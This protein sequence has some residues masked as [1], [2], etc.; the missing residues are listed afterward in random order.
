M[1]R[2]AL[3]AFLLLSAAAARAVEDDAEG[4]KDPQQLKRYPGTR[5]NSCDDKEYDEAEVPVR[6]DAEKNEVTE[7]LGGHVQIYDYNQPEHASEIQISRNIE[8]ALSKAGY[9]I[10]VGNK[11]G[12]TCCDVTA[13]SKNLYVAAQVSGGGINV[14]IIEVKPMEQKMDAPDASAM[15]E[16]LNKSGHVAVYGINFDT[17]KSNLKDDSESVLTE[18]AKLLTD[19]AD[20]K[21][22]VEGH[23]DNQ[24]KSKENLALSKKR[25][26][27]VK[28]WLV[29][30][31]VEA[32]RL[33]TEGF[34]DQKPVGDNKTDEGK[35]K[36]RRVELV[37]L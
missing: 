13:Q 12:A 11:T 29:K 16:E 5:L 37:K 6:L 7:K 22:R 10:L 30:K 2:L 34:G 24:G 14:R 35:A 31:G 18:V 33:T 3:I 9:K 15:L 27:A 23:T 32:A 20:L 28:D 21:L 26:Q 8:N 19:N 17:G 25:A 36:N 4:C 1:H